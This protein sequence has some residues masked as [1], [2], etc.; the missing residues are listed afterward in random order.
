[1]LSMHMHKSQEI[2]WGMPL[3]IIFFQGVFCLCV[4]EED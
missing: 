3:Y 4:C 2:G 1:M